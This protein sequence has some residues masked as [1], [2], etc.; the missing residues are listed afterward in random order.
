LAQ[1]DWRVRLVKLADGY[2]NLM[3]A[4]PEKLPSAKKTLELL[5]GGDEPPLVRARA[6]LAELIELVRAGS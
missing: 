6:E 2:D 5:G 1:A 4:G 3:D